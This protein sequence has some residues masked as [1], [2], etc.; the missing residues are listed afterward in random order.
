MDIFICPACIIELYHS[1]L[2]EVMEKKIPGI[3]NSKLIFFFYLMKTFVANI[4][5]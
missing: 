5:T 1:G 3:E 4:M 2:V